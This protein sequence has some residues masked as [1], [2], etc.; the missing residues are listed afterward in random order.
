MSSK[1]AGV[2][3]G[4]GIATAETEKALKVVLEDLHQHCWIPKSQIH[5]DS[6]IWRN[7]Q[8]GVVVVSRWMADQN[9]WE[10]PSSR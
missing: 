8:S 5:D 3:L 10:T 1:E 6:E 7:G 2:S 4:Q 9:G